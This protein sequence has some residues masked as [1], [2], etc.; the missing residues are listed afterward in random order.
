MSRRQRQRDELRGLCESGAVARAV[1]LAFHHF[2]DY[3]RDDELVQT[4]AAAIDG[5]AG[6]AGP[7]VRRR[8]T[9]LCASYPAAGAAR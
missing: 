5:T 6:P 8:F 9:D 4:L 3:G 2:A 1:D 7:M